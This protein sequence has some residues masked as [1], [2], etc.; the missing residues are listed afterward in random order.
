[1][2]GQRLAEILRGEES[3]PQVHGDLSTYRREG[4]VRCLL[5]RPTTSGSTNW[6]AHRQFQL[7]A[8]FLKTVEVSEPKLMCHIDVRLVKE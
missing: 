1:M 6:V 5:I 2:M 7:V 3:W 8:D 4:W